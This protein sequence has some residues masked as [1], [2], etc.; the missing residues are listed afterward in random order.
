MSR[1]LFCHRWIWPWH[2]VGFYTGTHLTLW[3]HAGCRP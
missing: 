1:C 2:H 3:W